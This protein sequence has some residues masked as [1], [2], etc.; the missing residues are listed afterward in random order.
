MTGD[1]VVDDAAV[2]RGRVGEDL[3]KLADAVV[4]LD[5]REGWAGDLRG[6]GV[7]VAEPG[8]LR[9]CR[10][11]CLDPLLALASFDRRVS[12]SGLFWGDLV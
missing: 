9:E 4:D 3:V 5:R 1:E 2:V 6:V 8:P 12:E 11:H 10:G 7:A